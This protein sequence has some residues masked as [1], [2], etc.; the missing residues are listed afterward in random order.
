[1]SDVHEY[2]NGEIIVIWQPSK[3]IHSGRCVHGLP[4][5]F[6]LQNRPWIQPLRAAT[7][8]VIAQVER[9]PSGALTWRREGPE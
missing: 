6:N 1:M 9:C 5:V 7:E 8:S 2:P 3:C 4:E